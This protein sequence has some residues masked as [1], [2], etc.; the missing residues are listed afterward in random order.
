MFAYE[1]TNEPM[2]VGRLKKVKLRNDRVLYI[3][4]TFDGRVPPIAF[5]Q[6]KPLQAALDIRNWELSRTHWAI[7]DEDLF[8]VLTGAGLVPGDAVSP[9]V[10]KADLPPVSAPE[11]QANTV[12]AFIEEVLNLD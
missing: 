9:K 10:E 12:G 3:E 4:P 1:G 2:R 11:F 5:E 6:I 7:K 8:D